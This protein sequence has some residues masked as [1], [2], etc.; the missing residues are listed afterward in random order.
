M[1]ALAFEQ[2]II[3]YTRVVTDDCQICEN[4]KRKQSW[5][6]LN[7]AEKITIQRWV[8][9]S[10]RSN[11]NYNICD[12]SQYVDRDFLQGLIGEYEFCYYKDCRVKLQYACRN[13]D[14]A[15]LDRLD[16]SKGYIKSN[17]VLSCLKCNFCSSFLYN[18]VF[19]TAH[20][21]NITF[22]GTENYFPHLMYVFVSYKVFNLLNAA[23]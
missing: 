11:K 3:K 14:M 5:G 4:D 17:C 13:K 10:R 8:R 9:N 12:K 20:V 21:K 7:E 2:K 23:R 19:E 22:P 15:T 1:K 6:A 18:L 16:D